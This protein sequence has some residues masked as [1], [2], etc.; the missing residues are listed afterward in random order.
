MN[1]SGTHTPY[2]EVLA[3]LELAR[4]TVCAIASGCERFTISIPARPD[5]D[6]DLIVC[7]ALEAA[8][9]VIASFAP[10]AADA[11]I[12]HADERSHTQEQAYRG[13]DQQGNRRSAINADAL[14]IAQELERSHVPKD[15]AKKLSDLVPTNWCDE[16]LTGPNGI[17]QPPY[18]CRHIEKLLRG[19]QDRIRAAEQK[20]V[21]R[22]ST[23]T[24]DQK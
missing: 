13:V 17:G 5:R 20:K 12:A 1:H 18:D 11:G 22:P 14:R 10:S 6:T 9:K 16:L 21:R 2:V 3:K 19:V 15:K 24:K 7:D 23:T 4:K 8:R